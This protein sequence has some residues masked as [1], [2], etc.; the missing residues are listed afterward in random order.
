MNLSEFF[1]R[2]TP[3]DEGHADSVTLQSLFDQQK[4]LRRDSAG[5]KTKRPRA[6]RLVLTSIQSVAWWKTPF[7]GFGDTHFKGHEGLYESVWSES[8]WVQSSCFFPLIFETDGHDFE[9][10][11]AKEV[12]EW[13]DF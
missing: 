5:C 4:L 3:V 2:K 1:L 12:E 7:L 11:E 6:A 13:E 10:H 9:I 8:F